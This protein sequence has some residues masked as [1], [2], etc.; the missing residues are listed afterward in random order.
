[1][2]GLQGIAVCLV[3]I[4]LAACGGGGGGSGGSACADGDIRANFSYPNGLQGN[5]G[6]PA[7]SV[8]A[9]SGVPTSCS[10]S[11][12]F[13]LSTGSLPPGMSLDSRTGVV[14]GTPTASGLFFFEVRMTV[15][16]FIGFLSGGVTANINNTAA[17]T[18]SGW[19]EMTTQAPFLNDFR[20]AALGGKLYAV[21]RGFYSHV[22]ETYEST[23]GGAT[24]TLLPI[25][26]PTGDLRGFA[27]ASDAAG[28]FF[29][30]E[31]TAPA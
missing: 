6:T 9:V 30:G 14:A 21:S 23:D 29:S 27:L 10:D 1:V 15:N 5:I 12:R 3:T 20:L 22:V 31:A 13:A 11:T 8:P 28:I 16:N 7:S 24:W 2:R 4:L 17:Q 18:L 26:G 25:A 19:E